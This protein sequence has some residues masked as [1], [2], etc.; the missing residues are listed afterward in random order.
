MFGRSVTS[1]RAEMKISAI[2]LKYATIEGVIFYIFVGK[3]T[4]TTLSQET[5]I[6]AL[7]HKNSF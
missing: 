6:F 7:V 5:Y 1:V 2:L 3:K 4:C